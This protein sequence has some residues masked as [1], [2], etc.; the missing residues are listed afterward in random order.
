MQNRIRHWL[1]IAACLLPVCLGCASLK[2]WW[3]NGG[4]VGPE[5]CR[6]ASN[7]AARWIDE[8]DQRLHI[9]SSENGTWWGVFNDSC[10]NRL[11]SEAYRQ[12]LTLRAA[13]CRVLEARAQKAIACGHLLPQS[14]AAFADF[15][16]NRLSVNTANQQY[17]TQP[18]F[19]LWDGGFNLAWEIDFWGRF[20]RAAEAA[21]AELDASVGNYDDV[22]MTLVADVGSTYVEIRTLQQR[23]AVLQTNIDIQREALRIAEVRFKEGKSTEFDQQ[24]ARTD[25]EKTKAQLPALEIAL[26]QAS[27][28]LCVLRGMPP[29]DLNAELGFGEIPQAPSEVVVGIPAALLG[30]RPDVRR[31]ERELAAQSAKIGV[32][33]SEFY[34]RIALS[35]TIGIAAEDFRN[36][37]H[38]DSMIGSIGPSLRWN[39]LN[40]GRLLNNVRVQDARCRQLALLYQQKVL[41]ANLEVEDALIAFLRNR[42]RVA[43]LSASVEAAR[44]AVEISIVQYREKKDFIFTSVSTVQQSLAQQEDLLAQAKGEVSRNLIAVYRALGGGWQIRLGGDL[45][46]SAP[47]PPAGSHPATR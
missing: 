15:N 30:R 1:I 44:R 24:Q 43:T 10:L 19:D 12:N 2:Q 11:I 20:R 23:L 28:R 18:S 38:S 8:N 26:R 7:V 17:T 34:P 25:L 27:N 4:K 37:F 36:L 39:I 47:R 5:Y 22:L 16:R 33:E 6:P 45:T 32:A 21:D 41:Q 3:L 40:Y 29:Q 14:Q 31:A 9:E 42:D 46:K 35:G 13:G